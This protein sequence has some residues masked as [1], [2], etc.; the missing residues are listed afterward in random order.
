MIFAAWYAIQ[1]PLLRRHVIMLI[2]ALKGAGSSDSSITVR[3]LPRYV[4]EF[5]AAE[6]YRSHVPV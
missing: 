5:V 3:R 4:E 6:S 2:A 1:G